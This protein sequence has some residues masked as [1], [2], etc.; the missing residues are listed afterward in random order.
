MVPVAARDLGEGTSPREVQQREGEGASH[1]FPKVSIAILL[2]VVHASHG[3]ACMLLLEPSPW[4]HARCDL[5]TTF[6][7]ASLFVPEIASGPL[8]RD[9]ELGSCQPGC[10]F[11]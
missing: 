8:G 5:V 10:P 2:N 9:Q 6:F 1:M 11:A 3:K 7:L 4:P